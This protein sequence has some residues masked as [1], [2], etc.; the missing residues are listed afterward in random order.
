MSEEAIPLLF[1]IPY[2]LRFQI[3]S[4]ALD[5]PVNFVFHSPVQTS[6]W[7]ETVK[8]EEDFARDFGR[9]RSRNHPCTLTI[10]IP[11]LTHI[12]PLPYLLISH[13]FSAEITAVAN[14][15]NAHLPT[16][17]SKYTKGEHPHVHLDREAINNAEIFPELPF[18][19]RIVFAGFASNTLTT[20]VEEL[21]ER[22]CKAVEGVYFTKKN[23]VRTAAGVGKIWRG[24]AAA[25][26]GLDQNTVD[27]SGDAVTPLPAN[28][29][30]EY[31]ST[32]LRNQ[33]FSPKDSLMGLLLRSKFP[34][35]K[36]ITVCIYGKKFRG[37]Y[38]HPA[39]KE[40]FTLLERNLI[41]NLDIVYDYNESEESL[42]RSSLAR[43]AEF[44]DW[45]RLAGRFGEHVEEEGEDGRTVWRMRRAEDEGFAARRVSDGTVE[46]W[47]RYVETWDESDVE[48]GKEVRV[49]QT[50]A[51]WRISKDEDGEGGD[52][53]GDCGYEW[54][55][56]HEGRHSRWWGMVRAMRSLPWGELWYDT[57]WDYVL[58]WVLR[59]QTANYVYSY[60]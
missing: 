13:R 50:G 27:G 39:L 32:S 29:L 53:G 42:L 47:G 1:R 20:M 44:K 45:D 9:K 17:L 18:R 30:Q 48:G 52:E 56:S 11:P 16:S 28:P 49:V 40:L 22:F 43:H 6:E 46:R 41:K 12:T 10:S 37:G 2:E 24:G 54:V 14:Y 34:H 36:T 19:G 31:L 35:L 23:L 51:V 26:L 25:D 5:I 8:P 55:K 4:E 38:M 60:K 3:F 21:P 15:L 57:T 7:R 59:R 58:P 33:T